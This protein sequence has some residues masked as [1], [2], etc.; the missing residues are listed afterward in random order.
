MVG[1]SQGELLNKAEAEEKNYNWEKAAD[2]YEQ[3]AKEELNQNRLEYAAKVYDK[4]GSICIRAVLASN[5]KEDYLFWNEKSVKAFVKA[6]SFFNQTNY[7]LL[8]SKTYTI[9]VAYAFHF[10][11]IKSYTISMV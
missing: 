8:G 9:S 11:R 7:K 4:F 5:T 6:E 3:V 2:L 1:I 10:L